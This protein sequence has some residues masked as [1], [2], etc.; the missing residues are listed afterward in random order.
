MKHLLLFLAFVTLAACGGGGGNGGNNGGGGGSSGYTVSGFIVSSITG[1]P[2]A[3]ATVTLTGAASASTTSDG[4]GFYSFTML[5]NGDYSL[6]ASHPDTVFVPNSEPV[7]VNSAAV[8]DVNFAG[9]RLVTI[10]TGVQF[11]PPSQSGSIQLRASLHVDNGELLY[12]DSGDMRLRAQPL[13]GSPGTGLVR[14]FEKV[15]SVMRHDAATWRVEGGDLYKTDAAGTTTLVA[16]GLR[17]A[18]T[19]TT[20]QVLFDDSAALRVDATPVANPCIPACEWDI[21]R[22]P[23]AGGAAQVLA[24]VDARVVALAQDDAT[25]YWLEFG[26]DFATPGCD[27]GTQLKSVPKSGGAVPT[28]ADGNLNGFLADGIWSSRVPTGGMVI[29]G[30]EIIF[31]ITR[32]DRYNIL[33]VPVTGGTVRMVAE[34]VAPV[35]IEQNVIYDIRSDG[36]NAYWLDRMAAAL[37][38]VRLA[39]GNVTTIAANLANPRALLIRDADA[40]W[41][42]AGEINGCC[43][44]E[45][46]GRISKV[47]LAGGAA[48]TVVDELD[49]PEVM[50]ADATTLAWS[51][52]WRVGVAGL[53]GSNVRTQSSGI[54]SPMARFTV[55]ASGIYIL[56]E[57][58]VKFVPRAGG[59]PEKIAL[60]RLGLVDD[61]SVQDIDILVDDT[62][63]F[64]SVSPDDETPTLLSIPLAGGDPATLNSSIVSPGPYNC[65]RRIALDP[66]Y[67]YWSESSPS[68]NDGCV[69]RRLPKT[70]GTAETIADQEYMSDFTVDG[71]DVYFT[72]RINLGPDHPAMLRT[73]RDGGD[74]TRFASSDPWILANNSQSV[75]WASESGFIGKISK[76]AVDPMDWF[77]LP[78]D[79]MWFDQIIAFE[80]LLAT[81]DGVY[82]TDVR[83]GFIY[84]AY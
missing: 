28:I 51:E 21:Q 5:A 48:V 35:G 57:G 41:L 24:T 78:I 29:A 33:A 75:F 42:E 8:A 12:T 37:R 31:A 16:D 60:A 22:I 44:T 20:A 14:R 1:Q 49:K 27:C 40:Y 3:G 54:G 68:F 19:V 30:N 83:N 84:A 56:D 15:D 43:F 23:L 36:T 58:Y 69:V 50:A 10:A 17:S 4:T 32:G 80:G 82:Y 11:L 63:V 7:T 26:F 64:W 45:G 13:D 2:I 34:I 53:D 6:G 72:D 25:I 66:I 61:T 73:S 55:G 52:A 70:G 62:D 74:A 65:Y 47:P 79:E 39:G 67:V 81:E 18:D 71:T 9:T 59:M 76:S 46:S 77:Y 38:S